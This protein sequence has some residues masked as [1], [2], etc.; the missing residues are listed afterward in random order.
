MFAIFSDGD[1][2]VDSYRLLLG[3]HS[4]HIDEDAEQHFNISRIVVH[5]DYSNVTYDSDIS[6]LEVEGNIQFTK[7]V[8][9]V[10]L[11]SEDFPADHQCVI[12]GW[13]RTLGRN[14]LQSRVLRYTPLLIYY[15]YI[16]VDMKEGPVSVLILVTRAQTNGEVSSVRYCESY[17]CLDIL[18]LHL[19]HSFTTGI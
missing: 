12:T 2:D 17:G 15:M 1:L 9:P 10:C 6:L 14:W 8:R 4:L 19:F 13:G 7:E 5:P 3:K 11:T 16:C 18:I